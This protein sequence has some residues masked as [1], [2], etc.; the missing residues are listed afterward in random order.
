MTLDDRQLHTAINSATQSVDNIVIASTAVASDDFNDVVL[1]DE[2]EYGDTDDSTALIEEN[3]FEVHLAAATKTT[4][5]LLHAKNT[6]R[7]YNLYL[8]GGR[9]YCAAIGKVGAL[10]T[11]TK[12]TPLVLKA[13]IASKCERIVQ[14]DQ[15][16]DQEAEREV[17]LLG[18]DGNSDASRPK[19]KK[20]SKDKKEDP[21]PRSLSTAEA[22]RAAWKLFYRRTFKVQDGWRIEEDGR[23]IG[24]PVDDID[25]SQYIQTLRKQHNRER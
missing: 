2:E 12:D 15:E 9:N 6:T 20:K 18:Q 7:N 10:D 3:A 1:D 23:C 13:Y 11:I 8:K 25:L 4:N 16:A 24:N 22:I 21:Q 14:E 5:D 19:N 17:G